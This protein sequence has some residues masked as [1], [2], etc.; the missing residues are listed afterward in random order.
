MPS[1]KRNYKKIR[2]SDD[3]N[4]A[5]LKLILAAERLFAE[6]GLSGVSLREINE[7]A[8]SRN[9]SAVHY[10]FGSREG[11]VRAIVEHRVPAIGARRA[12]LL[13]ELRNEKRGADIRALLNCLIKPLVAELL[14]RPEGNYYLRFSERFRREIKH[15]PKAYTE[16]V[17]SGWVQ[18]KKSIRDA[19][20]FLPPTV[21]EYRTRFGDEMAVST[22]ASIEAGL[23]EGD[24]SPADLPLMLEILIDGIAA[25]YLAPVTPETSR[26]LSGRNG[27]AR[28]SK[29]RKAR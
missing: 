6:H 13:E 7:A 10:H 19:L 16:D 4:T 28:A 12:V 21:I 2:P 15:F 27:S 8:G 14:P 25:A 11:V 17:V 3:A 9:A 23:A 24:L 22:L 26:A 20:F 1:N 5:R 18:T 29:S